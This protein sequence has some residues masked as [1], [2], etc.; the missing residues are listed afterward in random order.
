M[1]ALQYRPSN[2]NDFDAIYALYMHPS[3]NPHLAFD[4]VPKE[5]FLI[6]YRKLLTE[7]E[8]IV[9]TGNGSIIGSYH[10]FNKEYR[11]AD[12]LYLATFV[13]DPSHCGRGYG[14]MVLRHIINTAGARKKNRIELE[15]SVS[16]TNAVRFYEKHGFV[17]EGTIRQS[18]RIAPHAV[19]Y[20]DYLMSILIPWT[21]IV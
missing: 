16:N 11:Q 18:Y 10:L 20:D 7:G 21:V 13:I 1:N 3:T 5:E 8:L 14:S 17:I 19:Y 15:V 2:E 4:V 12:T 9:A 6:T